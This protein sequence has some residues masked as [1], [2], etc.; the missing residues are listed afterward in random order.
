MRRPRVRRGWSRS[1]PIGPEIDPGLIDAAAKYTTALG[2]APQQ[3]QGSP[4]R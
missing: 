4:V 1:S 3:P 2:I